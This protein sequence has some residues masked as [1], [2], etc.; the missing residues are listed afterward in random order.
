MRQVPNKISFL[1]DHDRHVTSQRNH[2]LLREK[3]CHQIK[4][5]AVLPSYRSG[6]ELESAKGHELP[7]HHLIAA[8]PVYNHPTHGQADVIGLFLPDSVTT[9]GGSFMRATLA[10]TITTASLAHIVHL[11]KMTFHTFEL[12]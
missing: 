6:P 7:P 9:S 5:F 12:R 11:L 2:Y 8:R 4:E 3:R 1:V 10:K